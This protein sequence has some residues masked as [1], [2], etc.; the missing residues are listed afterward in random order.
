MSDYPILKY[1]KKYGM[2]DMGK[3]TAKK[4]QGNLKPGMHNDG[5]GLYLRVS[6]TGG[7]SW[8]LRCRVHGIKR[9]IGLVV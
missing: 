9:D 8:I 1:G 5:A 3:L 7:R 2:T 4:V 6:N